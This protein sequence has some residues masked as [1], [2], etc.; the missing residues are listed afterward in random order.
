MGPPPKPP[1]VEK[2]PQSINPAKISH[3]VF[4]RILPAPCRNF[5]REGIMTESISFS[6]GRPPDIQHPD[7]GARETNNDRL[8]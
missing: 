3:S 2:N 8:F 1:M 6:N 5:I 7:T 4:G